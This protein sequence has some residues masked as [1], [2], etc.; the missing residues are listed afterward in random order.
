M[1]ETDS[2]GTEAAVDLIHRAGGLAFLA[3]PLV[4]DTDLVNLAHMIAEMREFGLDG[5]EGFYSDAGPVEQQ[6]LIDLADHLG[7]L[8]SAGTDLHHLGGTDKIELGIAMPMDKW[9]Q[10]TSALFKSASPAEHGN[11]KRIVLSADNGPQRSPKAPWFLLRPRIVLPSV[12]AIALFVIAIWG[13][14]L[15]TMERILLDRK[16]EMIRE[17]THMALSLL[18]ETQREER[19]GRLSR[20]EAQ[21]RAKSHINALRYGKDGKD[22]FWIQDM[23]PRMIMHPYRPDLNGKDV[24]GVT[25]PR[26]VPIFSEFA[27]LVR[28]RDNGFAAYVWQ[29]KDD[30][31]RLAAKESYIAKFEPWQWIIGT[32]IYT[33][34]VMA[35][36]RRIEQNLVYA[37]SAIVVLTIIVLLINVR[38]SLTVER[39]RMDM[40]QN[41]KQ[42]EERYRS[43]I[44]ATTEA[45]VLIV[46]DRCRYGNPTF[47][48]MTG[49]GI[50]KL[51]LL[52]IDD[53]LPP[54]HENNHIRAQ[55]GRIPDDQ[56]GTR[57]FDAVM[58]GAQNRRRQCMI[59]LN[60]IVFS[61]Q[62]GMI[63]LARDIYPTPLEAE[64]IHRL[65]RAAQLAPS[66]FFQTA[67][68]PPC[69]ITAMNAA[70]R[71]IFETVCGVQTSAYALAD[72]FDDKDD[73]SHLLQTMSANGTIENR[74]IIKT[75]ADG[76][77]H[78]LSLSI[79]Q[80]ASSPDGPDLF[81]CTAGDISRRIDME[82][83][84]PIGSIEAA[85][86]MLSFRPQGPEA[87]LR[88]IAEAVS[89]T[90]VID[91]CKRLPE[92]VQML[93]HLGANPRTASHLTTAVSDAATIRFIQ[94]ASD[95]LGQPPVPFAF[96]AMGSQGRREQTLY[97]DQD[98]GI[99]FETP[100]DSAGHGV[101]DYFL[102]LGSKVCQ[103]LDEAGYAL[104]TGDVMANNPKWCGPLSQWKDNFAQWIFKAEPQEL[105]DL[106]ICL[107]FRPVYGS[108]GLSWQLRRHVD[109]LVE[110]RPRLFP[111]LARNAMLFKPPARIMGKMVIAGNPLK[112]PDKIDLK[113]AMMPL[114][115]FA[116]L[117]A[118]R[119]KIPLTHT[120]E[121]ARGLNWKAKLP[122]ERT[123]ALTAAFDSLLGLRFR[124]QLD[125]LNNGVLP[126]NTI[127]LTTLND[128]ELKLI[129][130]VFDQIDTL[131]K[132][133][134]RDY[135]S[136]AP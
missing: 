20:N 52:T 117:Y 58:A 111:H 12:L 77:V 69:T 66:A 112:R 72:M 86:R 81:F 56:I 64:A 68:E 30:P 134:V 38:Q 53:L 10:L 3:H 95:R 60:P 73:L 129:Q 36:I 113:E 17:M 45:T 43:L 76:S 13:M 14:A 27:S 90:Q 8:V 96:I 6:T 47:Q 33:D 57:S 35:E 101:V 24:S 122:H 22:Y 83:S 18:A 103:R 44:E 42:A 100:E 135:P 121:R 71:E 120:V 123:H 39:K 51:E 85:S 54:I 109:A 4:I 5:I 37:L 126:P 84:G 119:H 9:R 48:K 26:G 87:L 132:D 99:I 50:E 131:Q 136:S 94:L 82:D 104:C 62:P 11:P 75:A 21:E 108:I 67:T 124:G 105:L 74:R 133:I 92:L 118:L 7:L 80:E 106:S 55:L 41:L 93:L 78:V 1:A 63:L 107:D 19:E 114:I 49:F 79:R 127:D 40:Q 23:Q 97:T 89:A 46:N 16:R 130:Q 15:P 70:G 61:G 59:T 88:E 2:I 34:D 25:D 32:G 31:Q 28:K 116:R 91:C 110:E 65:G 98:N 128:F 29:W 102:S 125:N 115:G